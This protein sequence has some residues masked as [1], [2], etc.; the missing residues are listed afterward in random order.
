MK[1][2][3]KLG[4]ILFLIS[5]VAAAAL[6][7]VN[8]ITKEPIAE[9]SML[10]DT[11]S[12][13][14]LLPA[15]SSFEKL[16]INAPESYPLIT[17]VYEGMAG[18]DPCGYTFKTVPKGY[19]GEIEVLVGV[20]TK[21]AITGV[22]IGNQNETPGLGTKAKDDKFK[23]QYEGKTS[24]LTVIKSGTPKDDEISAI[25]GATIS[26]RAVTSGVNEALKYYQE[27]L[28]DNN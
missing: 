24:E 20:D 9:A 17:E 3:I 22:N 13:Q 1:E 12:R 27:N 8:A 21:G 26:S 10:A 11:A 14:Q 25:S 23:G 19:G 5:A 15:A 2:I 4:L 7:F 16:D 6:G 18:S 28:S